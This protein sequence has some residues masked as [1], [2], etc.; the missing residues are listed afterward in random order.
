MSTSNERV[1]CTTQLA[2]LSFNHSIGHTHSRRFSTFYKNRCKKLSI[3]LRWQQIGF[4]SGLREERRTPWATYRPLDHGSTWHLRGHHLL[5]PALPDTTRVGRGLL[6]CRDRRSIV[7]WTVF[8]QSV[9]N[10]Q[11]GSA[12][13]PAT[14]PWTKNPRKPTFPPR[15]PH[16]G[17][18]SVSSAGS[19]F[20]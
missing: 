2:K 16:S 4:F 15:V 11:R 17:G 12:S 10:F 7:A 5:S 9:D 14:A 1:W 13:S 8:D 6:L 18:T 3:P 20:E 19:F